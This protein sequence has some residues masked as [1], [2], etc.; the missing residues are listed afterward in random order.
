MDSFFF[1][2]RNIPDAAAVAYFILSGTLRPFNLKDL[3]KLMRFFH[4]VYIYC[5]HMNKAVFRRK[6]FQKS[7]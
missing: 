3:F 5:F 1:K 7:S 2:I 4:A 6:G